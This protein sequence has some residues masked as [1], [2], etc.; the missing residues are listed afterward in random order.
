[1]KS[2]FLNAK[3]F[4]AL[5]PTHSVV[6]GWKLHSDSCWPLNFIVSEVGDQWIVS[7][8]CGGL[9]EVTMNLWPHTFLRGILQLFKNTK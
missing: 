9:P 6:Q 1:M 7:R 8:D 4:Q 3:D 2:V 5:T